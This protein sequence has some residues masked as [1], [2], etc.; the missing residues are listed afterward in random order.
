MPHASALP[1]KQGNCMILRKSLLPLLWLPLFVFS[2][3]SAFAQ[4]TYTQQDENLH[5]AKGMEL[6]EKQKYAAAREAFRKQKEQEP[7]NLLS[8]EAAYYEAIAAL[9]AGSTES[10]MLAERFVSQ[11]PEHPKAVLI[12]DEVGKYYYRQKDYPKAIEYLEKVAT[13]RLSAERRLETQF[14]LGYAYFTQK[15][16]DKA[17]GQLAPL[18]KYKNTY[19]NAAA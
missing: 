3:T 17:I 1:S 18:K 7:Q 4:N 15:Q 19:T 13:D 12:Y 6:W 14:Q 2:A 9:Y 16:Y 11:Y 10:L 5:F 8:I